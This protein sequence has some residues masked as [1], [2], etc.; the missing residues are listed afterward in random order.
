MGE[1]RE[2]R[3]R[4]ERISLNTEEIRA[5]E[6][7]TDAA[8]EAVQRDEL[9]RLRAATDRI[10]A[11]PDLSDA[12]MARVLAA[13]DPLEELAERTAELRVE[14]GFVDAVMDEIGERKSILPDGIMKT[15]RPSILMASLA[16]AACLLLSW[17]AERE[18][19]FDS[20]ERIDAQ[21]EAR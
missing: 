5:G 2:N 13:S 15:A 9:D 7:F 8:M 11:S 3:R 1:E 12:V 20:F 18:F 10:S 16:A 14:D 4:L 6:A 17:Y 21:A 19:V